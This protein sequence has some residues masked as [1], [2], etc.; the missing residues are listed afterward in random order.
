MDPDALLEVARRAAH[1]AGE[2]LLRRFRAPARGVGVKSSTTDMVSDADRDAEALIRGILRESRP[3]DAIL[4]EETGEEPGGTGLRWVIDP[5]DGTTNFLFGVPQWAVSV[6]CEDSRGG[7]VGVVHGPCQDE[8]FSA[9]RGGGASLGGEALRVS[10]RTDLSDALVATGFSYLP[11]ERAE[12][13]AQLA[14]VL[15]RVRD[16]RRPG[17]AALDLA[18]TAAARFDAYY[19]V[20]THHWDWA[21]AVVIVREAGGVVSELPA[22]GPS[23]PGLVSGPPALHDALRALLTGE[24]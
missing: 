23:G 20:P 9:I 8:T 24:R 4:G 10:E 17:A 19:E 7:L 12:Q 14:R 3:D 22:V 13:A 5:L 16:V 6:A 18:W 1:A 15:P 2:L 21:A 11:E